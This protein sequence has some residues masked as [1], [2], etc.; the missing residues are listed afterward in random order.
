MGIFIG[1]HDMSQI[2]NVTED[3]E[4]CFSTNPLNADILCKFVGSS[5]SGAKT[6][7]VNCRPFVIFQ[8]IDSSKNSRIKH[9]QW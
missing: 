3:L 8:K 2:K 6:S 9:D 7:D 1:L 5:V 4:I